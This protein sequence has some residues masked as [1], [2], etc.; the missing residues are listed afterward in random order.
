VESGLNAGMKV[1]AVPSPYVLGDPI[2]KRAIFCLESLEEFVMNAE[3]L[4]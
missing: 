1:V 3:G 4:S 2:F